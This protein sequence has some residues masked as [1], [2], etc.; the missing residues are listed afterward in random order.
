MTSPFPRVNARFLWKRIPVA[1]KAGN[2]ELEQMHKV[3]KSLW[4]NEMVEFYKLMDG[5]KWSQGVAEVMY[6]LKEKVQADNIQLISYAYS[7]IHENVFAEM[8]NQTPDMI[9]DTCKRMNWE[10]QEG[11]APRLIIPKKPIVDKVSALNAEDQLHK[12]TSYVSFL[13]N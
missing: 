2:E 11:P 9:A 8:T 6:E 10:I 1:A 5:Y 13:E 4:K 3:Y 12:L 7:S